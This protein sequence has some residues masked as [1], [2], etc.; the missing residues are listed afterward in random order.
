MYYSYCNIWLCYTAV[1]SKQTQQLYIPKMAEAPLTVFCCCRGNCQPQRLD[2]FLCSPHLY[3][4]SLQPPWLAPLQVWA[5]WP[6]RIKQDLKKNKNKL[7]T[8]SVLF[9]SLSS[10]CDACRKPGNRMRQGHIPNI[11]TDVHKCVLDLKTHS[12]LSPA[13]VTGKLQLNFH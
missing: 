1:S 13:E 8:P 11:H 9:V 10:L 6:A 3:R 12:G 5:E 2:A 7:K 4:T